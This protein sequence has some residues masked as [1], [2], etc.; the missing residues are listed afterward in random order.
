MP[1]TS[2]MLGYLIDAC[3]AETIAYLGAVGESQLQ[4]VLADAITIYDP[5]FT[6]EA[7][8]TDKVRFNAIGRALFWQW[9]LEYMQAST[10]TGAPGSP[11]EFA[12]HVAEVTRLRDWYWSQVPGGMPG[13]AIMVGTITG[14]KDPYVYPRY[15]DRI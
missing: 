10:V 12:A 4:G 13:P 2:T 6:L 15:E 7:Q 9:A 3:P 11:S 5:T 8:C 14:E 1:Y